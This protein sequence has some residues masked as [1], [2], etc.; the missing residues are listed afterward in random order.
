MVDIMV[1]VSNSMN[2]KNELIIVPI[3]KKLLKPSVV[4]IDV[5]ADK[6]IRNI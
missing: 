2:H 6:I 3:H 5:Y 1:S 4:I